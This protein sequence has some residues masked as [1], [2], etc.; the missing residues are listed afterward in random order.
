MTITDYLN[1]IRDY[2]D[3]QLAE[4]LGRRRALIWVLTKKDYEEQQN[5]GQTIADEAWNKACGLWMN[6]CEYSML[7]MWDYA[8]DAVVLATTEEN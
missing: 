5:E 1:P 7:E 4:E 8:H 2:T 6:M 3:E